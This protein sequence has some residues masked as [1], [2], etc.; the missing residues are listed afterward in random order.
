[1]K[2]QSNEKR[3]VLLTSCGMYPQVIT[4][5]IFALSQRDEPVE[6][7]EIYVITTEVGMDQIKRYLLDDTNGYFFRLC[8]EYD[9]TNTRFELSNV[10]L[11][12]NA[13]GIPLDD[14]QT[15]EDNEAVANTITELVRTLTSDPNTA[16]HVSLAGGRRTISYYLGY[17]LSLF[18]RPQDRL[19]HTIV[20]REFEADDEFFYPNKEPT[21]ITDDTG[22]TLNTQDAKVVL[23]EI[24]FV[25]LR[26]GLP[27]DLLEGKTTFVEAV[28][29]VPKITKGAQVQ[30]SLEKK[31]L[32]MN[33]IAIDLPPILFAWYSWLASRRKDRSEDE[34]AI[35]VR[36]KHHEEFLDFLK[37]LFGAR[38]PSVHRAAKALERGFTID[39]VSEKNSRINKKVSQALALHAYSFRIHSH[40]E[41][42]NTRYGLLLEPE[43][44]LVKDGLSRDR[45]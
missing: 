27:V 11:L 26:E 34:S 31:S 38:H 19:S 18:G 28:A 5:M 7:A 35:L 29:S 4:G 20:S 41:R 43:N 13:V 2:T 23:A 10:Q 44:I 15:S 1:M 14:I 45:I 8:R 9:L 39:Y 24:P 30:I 12:E 6:P 37:A 16:L 32:V 40:G 17:A 33:D 22:N 42:P 21:F 36:G 25:R 3:T